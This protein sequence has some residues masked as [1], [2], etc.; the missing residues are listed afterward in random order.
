MRCAFRCWCWVSPS[1]NHA[2][3]ALCRTCVMTFVYYGMRK[4]SIFTYAGFIPDTS[5]FASMKCVNALVVPRSL[6]PLI[7]TW[8]DVVHMVG[9][10][11]CKN[12]LRDRSSVTN[13]CLNRSRC[14]STAIQAHTW[15]GGVWW[16]K[17]TYAGGIMLCQDQGSFAFCQQCCVCASFIVCRFSW[18]DHHTMAYWRL[19]I[20]HIA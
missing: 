14:G 15:E 4:D 13:T 17:R 6:Y 10:G 2:L 5:V 9:H 12:C 16:G 1:V 7:P 11:P 3:H 8:R 18:C 19:S 20:S